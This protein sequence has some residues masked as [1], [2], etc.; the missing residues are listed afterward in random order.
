ME[1]A[2]RLFK[3]TREFLTPVLKESAFL[4]T[5]MLTPEEFVR[6]GDHLVRVSPSWK[7]E[8]GDPS[9][10]KSYL[11]NG[12]QYLITRSV[13]C[14]QRVA[15]LHAASMVQES[16]AIDGI[17]GE[18][19]CHTQF[20]A[21]KS[22]QEDEDI[23]IVDIDSLET[24]KVESVNN[25]TSDYIDMED[26]SLVLDS[27]TAISSTLDKNNG[28]VKIRRYD[29]SISYDN[30]YRTPRIWL[31]GYNENGSPL[32]AAATFEVSTLA[33][34]LTQWTD[35]VFSIGCSARLCQK[36]CYHR[37]TPTYQ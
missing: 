3:S 37:P 9:N 26:D 13:P 18:E 11:P 27:A 28:V 32:D 35:D 23:E 24:N 5:G 36:N 19:W 25:S 7:W 34:K 6:A 14:Y 8:N 1:E 4:E 10:V 33:A 31:Y 15:A 2:F 30:Y 12:K 29:V 21:A 16:I 17:N 22:A 20:D